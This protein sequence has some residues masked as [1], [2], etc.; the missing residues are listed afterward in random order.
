MKLIYDTYKA[1]TQCLQN[2]FQEGIHEDYL[3]ELDDPDMVLTDEHPSIIYQHIVD[4]YVKIDLRM[5][6]DNRK[7]FNAPLD[8]S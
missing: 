4:R 3:A 8:P 1:V 2:Q 7:Q 5:A 6:D